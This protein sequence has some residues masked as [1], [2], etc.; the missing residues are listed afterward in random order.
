MIPFVPY[1]SGLPNG[2]I[3]RRMGVGTPTLL[4]RK[5]FVVASWSGHDRLRY[6]F[7]SVES[8]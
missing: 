6:F 2:F 5:R 4:S 7:V 8:I 3:S 1:P